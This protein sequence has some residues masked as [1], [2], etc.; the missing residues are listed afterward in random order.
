[1]LLNNIKN[2][3]VKVFFSTKAKQQR[4]QQT[5]RVLNQQ[6]AIQSL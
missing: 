2:I 5:S 1:M 3:F 4:Q 6:R